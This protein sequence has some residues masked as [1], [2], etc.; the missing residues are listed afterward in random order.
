MGLNLKKLNV[1]NTRQYENVGV[2]K[3]SETPYSFT[4]EKCTADPQLWVFFSEIV[5][6]NFPFSTTEESLYNGAVHCFLSPISHLSHP[7]LENS[8][9]E[10]N[11]SWQHCRYCMVWSTEATPGLL[12]LSASWQCLKS[13]RKVYWVTG[14]KVAWSQRLKMTV[15]LNG[16]A[17]LM[18]PSA[19]LWSE[20]IK[21]FFKKALSKCAHCAVGQGQG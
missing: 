18:S 13:Q 20:K 8:S 14:D 2:L 16:G 17:R 3:R 12:F 19:I 6:R 21:H 11:E 15:S 10:E 9:P 5:G 1:I 7:W 4:G